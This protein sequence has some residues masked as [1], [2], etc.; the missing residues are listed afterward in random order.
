MSICSEMRGQF[1]FR[2]CGPTTNRSI[3]GADVQR[4]DNQAYAGVGIIEVA[5]NAYPSE[6]ILPILWHGRAVSN[7]ATLTIAAEGAKLERH[8]RASDLADLATHLQ[9]P[10]PKADTGLQGGGLVLRETRLSTVEGRSIYL[11]LLILSLEPD[12][13]D[14]D[15]R[16]EL[17]GAS[18]KAS[19]PLSFDPAGMAL[20]Q[21]QKLPI[22]GWDEEPWGPVSTLALDIIDE[23]MKIEP[24]TNRPRTAAEEQRYQKHMRGPAGDLF[25]SREHDDKF[26]CYLRALRHRVPPL[27]WD[28]RITQAQQATREKLTASIIRELF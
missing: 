1:V 28:G 19:T 14:C 27:S 5:T 21:I 3:A 17:S 22:W 12:S 23:A 18:L 20:P 10:R 13:I 8:Q 2:D 7:A 4:S 24:L 6:Q 25:R 11:A 26:S 9:I 16:Y 15:L